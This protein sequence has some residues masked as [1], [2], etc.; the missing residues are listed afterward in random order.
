MTENKHTNVCALQG[1]LL[2]GFIYL[3]SACCHF[4]SVVSVMV[5]SPPLCSL[6][7]HLLS[8]RVTSLPPVWP[9]TARLLSSSSLRTAASPFSF[10]N[11]GCL[12]NVNWPNSYLQYFKLIWYGRKIEML[13]L[14]YLK[15]VQLK[16]MIINSIL[17]PSRSSLLLPL[18]PLPT[19]FGGQAFHLKLQPIKVTVHH[20]TS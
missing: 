14:V 4:K 19:S 5:C 9:V 8:P 7:S 2:S 13:N 18:F 12:S 3:C 15:H 10:R 17:K 6:L 16:D 1:H 11:R 20:L